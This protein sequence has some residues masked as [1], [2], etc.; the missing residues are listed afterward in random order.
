MVRNRPSELSK[1][2]AANRLMESLFWT[3]AKKFNLNSQNLASRIFKILEDNHEFAGRGIT[4]R[5][6]EDDIHSD[7]AREA[8]LREFFKENPSARQRVDDL[9]KKYTTRVP[10]VSIEVTDMDEIPAHFYDK[11]I[12]SLYPDKS[13]VSHN[14]T[15]QLAISVRNLMS[16]YGIFGKESRDLTPI[17]IPEK[18]YKQ[19]I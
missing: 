19:K 14:V 2:L 18:V 8:A 1:A 10:Y 15:S 7:R 6:F 9:I 13:L 17:M 11:S 3:L 4:A 16:L 12:E 5:V